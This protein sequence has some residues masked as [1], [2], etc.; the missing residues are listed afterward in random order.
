MDL[1]DTAE[2]NR[3]GNPAHT[4][5]IKTGGM[6]IAVLGH[7]VDLCYPKEHEKLKLAIEKNGMVL[8]EYPPGT[9]ARDFFFPR[10]NRIIAALSKTL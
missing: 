9:Q 4:A 1:A 2:R 8:S 3:S 5:A 7:G 6:T 10:R